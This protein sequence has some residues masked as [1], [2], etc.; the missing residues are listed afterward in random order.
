MKK[1]FLI[2]SFVL[3]LLGFRGCETVTGT[4]VTYDPWIQA[5]SDIQ[6]DWRND[7]TLPSIDTP[8]CQQ[9]LEGLEVRQATEQEWADRLRLCPY[10]EG[11]CSTIYDCS[12]AV[13]ATGTVQEQAGAFR[14]FL[15]PAENADGHVITVRHEVAH[16]LN[17]CTV[18]HFFA[19]PPHIF[20]GTGV[21][22]KGRKLLHLD[23]ERDP[24]AYC[25]FS[26]NI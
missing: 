21:V 7:P 23:G 10:V 26:S 1:V 15:S 2:I 12:G 8:H 3:L 4:P 14:V 16:V 5:V 18:G 20:G 13:C 17:W 25:L 6:E 24:E 9:A 22:W 11:G 19:H